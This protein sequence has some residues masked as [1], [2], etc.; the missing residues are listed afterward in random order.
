MEKLSMPNRD[1][2]TA[3]WTD[4]WFEALD[5]KQKLLFLYCWSNDHCNST[6]MYIITTKRISNET[7]IPL[8]EIKAMIPT[9]EPK[10]HYDPQVNL[11][12]VRNFV[13]IQKR[14]RSFIPSVLRYLAKIRPHRFL[15][16]FSEEYSEIVEFGPFFKEI[17]QMVQLDPNLT[18]SS[19]AG[20]GAGGSFGGSGGVG[21]KG[22]LEPKKKAPNPDHKAFMDFYYQTFMDHFGQP[23]HIVGGRDGT[24]IQRLVAHI[25][26]DELKEL[27]V[28]FFGS[29]DKFI[30]ATGY[31]LGIFESQIQKLRLAKQQSFGGERLWLERMGDGESGPKKIC[32]SDGKNPDYPAHLQK[33]N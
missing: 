17:G 5:H 29:D 12:W 10:V 1:L 19:G 2:S 20:A 21:G 31:T 6:G 9:L 30:Q 4:P 16:M 23:P 22:V 24:I 11:L 3:I 27:L 28:R 33:L 13:R 14:G 25:G 26:L 8:E 32:G 15:V 18:P 7:G